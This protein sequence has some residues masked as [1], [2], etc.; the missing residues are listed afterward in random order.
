MTAVP[1]ALA[2]ANPIAAYVATFAGVV[3]CK[4][5][6]DAVANKVDDTGIK[7]DGIER[8]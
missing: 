7:V 6:I 3:S 4:F 5:A 2:M 8:P 1:K